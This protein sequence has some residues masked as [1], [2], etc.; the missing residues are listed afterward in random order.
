M[1]SEQRFRISIFK[2]YVKG[3]SR[4]ES[5]EGRSR[6]GTSTREWEGIQMTVM[7]LIYRSLFNYNQQVNSASVNKRTERTLIPN[8]F[9][10]N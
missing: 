3:R 6:E 8:G 5:W 1:K 7:E 2:S 9:V 4:K 10:N